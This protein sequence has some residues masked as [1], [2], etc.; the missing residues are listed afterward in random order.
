MVDGKLIQKIVE[1]LQDL[2]D[3]SEEH[4]IPTEI[5]ELWDD[6][7]KNAKHGISYREI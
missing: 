3:I 4:K 5:I 6:K 7:E 2:M 1:D